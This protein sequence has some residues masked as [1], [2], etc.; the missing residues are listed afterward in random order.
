MF[1]TL[2][3]VLEVCDAKK[4]TMIHHLKTCPKKCKTSPVTIILRKTMKS[5]YFVL[6]TC[7]FVSALS[8][9]WFGSASMPYI[10]ITICPLFSASF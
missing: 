4:Q 2:I 5:Q 9:L 8:L 3:K 7:I 6:G 10:I 1:L